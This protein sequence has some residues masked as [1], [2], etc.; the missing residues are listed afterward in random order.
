MESL[1]CDIHIYLGTQ[2]ISI[3][4]M[5]DT[6]IFTV[7]TI[8]NIYETFTMCHVLFWT[9]HVHFLF[10]MSAEQVFGLCSECGN[11]GTK[12]FSNF[13]KFMKLVSGGAGAKARTA[14][15]TVLE[16]N[17]KKKSTCQYFFTQEIPINIDFI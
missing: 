11:R 6:I 2:C 3:E 16:T 12:Q 14:L 13:P 17:I 15:Y 7:L 4:D 1:G 10:W 8:T 5:S 9:R